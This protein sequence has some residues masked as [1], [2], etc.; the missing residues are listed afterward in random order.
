MFWRFVREKA[1]TTA[2]EYGIVAAMVSIVVLASVTLLGTA[3]STELG[4]VNDGMSANA[5]GGG[6]GGGNNGGG[7]GGGGGK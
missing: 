3:V 1:G 4:V 5:G 6:N 2:I 7:N